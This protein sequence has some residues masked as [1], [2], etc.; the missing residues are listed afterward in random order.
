ML[1]P[2]CIGLAPPDLPP[3]INPP[4]PSG[5]PLEDAHGLASLSEPPRGASRGVP[6]RDVNDR[7]GRRRF[8][9]LTTGITA[10]LV[11]AALLGCRAD[12]DVHQGSQVPAAGH[13]VHV[14]VPLAHSP[15]NRPPADLSLGILAQQVGDD[16]LDPLAR[17]LIY[18]RLFDFDPRSASVYGS[19]ATEVELVDPLLLRIRLRDDVYFHPSA[20]G[21]AY[22][23]TAEAVARDFDLRRSE[24]V[25][26]FTDVIEDI[27]SPGN[28]DLL[29]RLRAPFSLLFEH[30]SQP[31]AS[32]RDIRDYGGIPARLGSGPFFPLRQDGDD[33]ILSPNPLRQADERPSLSAVQVRRAAQSGDLDAL[34]V[35][36]QLDVREH[37]DVASRLTAHARRDRVELARPRQAMRGLALSLLAPVG[38]ASAATAAF[39]DDRVRRALSLAMNRAAL[40]FIDGS[41]LSGPIGPAFEGDAL[42][43]V[44]LEAHPL[45]QHNPEEAAALLAA[46]GHA[47]LTLRLSH[48]DSPVMLQIGQRMVDQL[49]TAGVGA[50]LVTRPPAEFQSAFLAGEFE[51]ALIELEQMV[52]PDIGLRLHTS[53]GLSGQRSPWGYSNPVYD[54]RVVK[55]LSQIDPALRTQ[56]AREAQRMLLDDTPALLPI[57]SPL[58]YASVAAGVAG[59]DFGAYD[60]NRTALST[61]WNGA[62][63]GDAEEGS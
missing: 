1:C 3:T 26:F 5:Q 63:P 25:F 4:T 54:A 59:Y 41:V 15:D 31:E 34:F 23:V 22:P 48:S 12:D 33:L 28:T 24:G 50:R 38:E 35:Q 51:A 61:H 20:A 47:D 52:S 57:N 30:L 44:E 7:L 27:E 62:R 18:S 16:G 58:E 29:L 56:H 13:R 2:P 39:R 32:I 14:R 17:S 11:S 10:G 46:A 60:F 40:N 21:E 42:P 37:P 6:R 49:A 45:L 9:G 53:G 36:G 19:L 43:Q 55:T 8:L